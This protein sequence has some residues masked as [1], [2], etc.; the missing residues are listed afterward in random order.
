MT[1]R[2][3]W[4][5]FRNNLVT[6]MERKGLKGYELARAAGIWPTNISNYLNKG[7]VPNGT[8]LIK[9]AGALGVEPGD[10][11]PGAG[12]A[13]PTR[14]KDDSSAYLI[15][16]RRALDELEGLLLTLVKELR[17]RWEH[18]SGGAR[19]AKMGGDATAPL[20]KEQGKRRS[21]GS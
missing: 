4:L 3:V 15:G 2:D 14:K 10:L 1:D 13:L 18:Q 7:S 8:N 21:K 19:L 16:G 17:K 6:F 11:I 5:K 9:I 12:R 20:A